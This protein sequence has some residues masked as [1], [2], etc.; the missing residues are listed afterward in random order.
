MTTMT[1]TKTPDYTSFADAALKAAARF[2]F[3]VAVAGQWMFAY[4]IA[5]RYGP[6]LRGHFQGWNSGT[7]HRYVPGD[8]I[9]N[10]AMGVHLLLAV[11]VTVGGPLQLI[12]QLRRLAPSFHRWNG[13]LY[14]PAVFV[15]SIAALY[16]VWIRGTVGDLLQ[17]LGV[18][19]D[20]LLI[21]TFAALA[22][23]YA[24]ARDFATHR[25]W[26]LRLFIVVS[27][28]WVFRVGLMLWILINHGPAGFDPKTLIGPFISFWSFGNYLLP[29][30]ILEIYLRTNDGAA[31]RGRFVMASALVVLTVAMG[32]GIFMTTVAMWLPHL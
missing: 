18:S 15:T 24:I 13:R 20:A 2:W 12:P 8:P 19:L 5:A 32:I 23:R 14:I 28:V 22:L 25:R 30:A 26:A 21:M 16:M 6:A 7:V 17:H 31:A 11:I 3:I 10:I 29:L 4:Y 27:G 1:L 9:G